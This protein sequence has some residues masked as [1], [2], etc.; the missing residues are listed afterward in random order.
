MLGNT[1]AASLIWGI[2][3]IF[4]LDAGLS[5]LEAFA[6]NAFFTAG[7][8][9]LRG[10]D[11]HRR[12]HVGAARLVPAR[13]G[14]PGGVD[15]ASTCC[16]GRSRRRSG[17]WALVSLLLGLGFTFFSGAVEAWLVDAL[18]ATGTTGPLESVLARGQ[19]VT[20]V[21][22]ARPARS[23]GGFLAQADQP[24]VCRSCCG[25]RSCSL[26]FIL[27]FALMRDLGFTPER[28]AARSPSMRDIA[29]HSIE[30]GWRVPAV[31]CSCWP[32]RSPAA[33]ASTF[34]R[35]AA[36]PARPLRRPDR[37]RDRRARRR[38]R[39]RRPDRRRA[40]RPV[41]AA[42]PPADLGADRRRGAQRAA[43]GPIGL[44]RELLAPWSC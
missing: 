32:R 26:M 7:M 6:A 20:G 16:C 39:R 11:R 23:R 24:R 18:A 12:R 41:L 14:D 4:L 29:A 33:S 3:T 34:L 5:N 42:L 40:S 21:G 35:P 15:R 10:A 30:Y 2:N 36:L 37:L 19:I 31:R 28:G 44:D 17:R 25:R 13:H 27:A 9:H 22:D 1:L 8:V 43:L 38:D